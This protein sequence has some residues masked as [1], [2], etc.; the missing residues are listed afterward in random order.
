MS[1]WSSLT[2]A[3]LIIWLVILL[4]PWRPW[5]TVE[6]IEALSNGDT[7]Y[8]LS[9]VS[10]LIPAR[11]EA[12]SIARTLRGVSA[13]GRVAKVI[14]VDDQS[15]DGTVAAARAENL[16][17]LEIVSGTAPMPGWSGKLWALNQGLGLIK[18][19]Y[20]LLLDADIELAP[21]IL[22]ALVKK[23]ED[24][25]RTMVSVMAKLSMVSWWESLLIP[26]FIYFFKLLYPFA[27]ANA[28]TR[29]VAAAAGGCV[30]IR[31]ESLHAIGGFAA[32][33]GALI[34]DC[35]LA[36]KI[37]EAGGRLWLGLS[38]AVRAIRPYPD[39]TSIWNMVARTAF[40]QLRYSLLLLILCSGSM[41]LLFAVPVLGLCV[42][43]A[44]VRGAALAALCV[45]FT[46]YWPTVKY[47]QCR[48]W[49]MLSLPV[50]AFLYLAMTWTSAVRFWFG[51]RSRWKN[52]I[53]DRER[54]AA[55]G[56]NH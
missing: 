6:R 52:R 1:A 10:V 55:T 21:G 19:P 4:L 3:A 38:T 15:V 49:W 14:V 53:Y 22:S 39:L 44:Y 17:T 23:L 25:D 12:D 34:D 13:Q 46:T 30:L 18:S 40:T 27:L 28:S 50:A 20:T 37:K 32:L 47:Y 56:S 51:E 54:P 45:M 31:T 9:C 5:S 16:T 11:D 29:W 41:L 2:A 48:W 7:G 42:Q 35:T 26:P 33:R 8:H 36:R 24:E 43:D